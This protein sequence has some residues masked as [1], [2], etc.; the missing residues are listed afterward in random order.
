LIENGLGPLEV[1]MMAPYKKL[2]PFLT[3]E[4]V[5][6]VQRKVRVIE[7]PGKILKPVHRVKYILSVYVDRHNLRGRP[8]D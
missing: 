8:G 5:R 4:R 3:A 2:A 6:P 1:V 7:P